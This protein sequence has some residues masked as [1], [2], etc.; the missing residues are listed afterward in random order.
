MLYF[1]LST[2]VLTLYIDVVLSLS[3]SEFQCTKPYLN[4]WWLLVN[5]ASSGN[6]HSHFASIS[7][8]I[9][10]D[11]SRNDCYSLSQQSQDWTMK[12]T[13]LSETTCF[14]GIV[15]L[16]HSG[17]LLDRVARWH[18]ASTPQ[19]MLIY[20]HS[21]V[22]QRSGDIHLRAI[23]QEIPSHWSLKWAWNSLKFHSNL[24]G[25]N[26]FCNTKT[27]THWNAPISPLRSLKIFE[28]W[29]NFTWE[30]LYSICIHRLLGSYFLQSRINNTFES[31]TTFL[32]NS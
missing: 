12:I 4:L 25:A 31:E 24:S 11:S 32:R 5:W 21:P 18:Q 1:L 20:H 27:Y 30:I 19:P 3:I 28:I 6:M 29:L 23:S 10:V 17:L 15:L 7:V 14:F 8:C 9:T 13:F 16:T 22:L 26:T 2:L